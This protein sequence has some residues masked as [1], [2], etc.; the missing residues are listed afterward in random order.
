VFRRNPRLDLLLTCKAAKARVLKLQTP[1]FPERPTGDGLGQEF[2]PEERLVINRDVGIVWM[3]GSTVIYMSSF[4]AC[5]GHKIW[6]A[7]EFCNELAHATVV[8][9]REFPPMEVSVADLGE[10]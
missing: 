7:M 6:S 1:L 8:M 5:Y 2:H 3:L 10:R 9:S 4:C